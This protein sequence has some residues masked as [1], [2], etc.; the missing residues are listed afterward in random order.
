MLRI[1][2]LY[3]K[4]YHIYPVLS[5]AFILFGDFSQFAAVELYEDIFPVTAGCFYNNIPAIPLIIFDTS[6]VKVHKE[7]YQ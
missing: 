2:F 4:S 7:N 1:Y 3:D 6:D 5:R